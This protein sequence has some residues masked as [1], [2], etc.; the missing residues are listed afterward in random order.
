MS[1]LDPA[2]L[3]ASAA[4]AAR[5]MKLLANERRLLILCQLAEGEASVGELATQIGLSQS[6]LSQ[7]L[8]IL[9]ADDIVRTRRESQTIWYRLG[10]P[11]AARMIESLADIFCPPTADG[12]AGA[13]R[14][15]AATRS[16]T[17]SAS[18]KRAR[19]KSSPG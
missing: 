2:Q 13:L 1:R 18:A 14:H 4:A 3:A 9:R 12:K 10:D 17:R 7:H 15:D 11:V 5:M 6:A 8:A 19:K 16:A